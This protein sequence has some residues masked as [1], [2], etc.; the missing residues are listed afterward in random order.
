MKGDAK[1]EE[2]EESEEEEREE[3]E[4]GG[5]RRVLRLTKAMAAQHLIQIQNLLFSFFLCLYLQ[6]SI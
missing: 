4:E 3:E 1:R 6:F 5:V 2:E